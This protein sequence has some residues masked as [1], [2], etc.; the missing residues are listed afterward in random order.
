MI[1]SLPLFEFE[2][3]STKT[4]IC[5]EAHAQAKVNKTVLNIIKNDVQI[6]SELKCAQTPGKL[7]LDVL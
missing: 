1:E 6:V 4:F 7:L 3:A 2:L 5:F